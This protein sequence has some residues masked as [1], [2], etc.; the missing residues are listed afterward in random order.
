MILVAGA[1]VREIV[2]RLGEEVGFRRSLTCLLH[3]LTLIM[4]VT[5]RVMMRTGTVMR[6]GEQLAMIGQGFRGVQLF[7]NV[8]GLLEEEEVMGMKPLYSRVEHLLRLLLLSCRVGYLPTSR[9][10]T[11]SLH[12]YSKQFLYPHLFL[13]LT[14]VQILVVMTLRPMLMMEK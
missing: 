7:M 2:N 4:R 8:R 13:H 3:L 9:G 5:V 10:T 11:F 1:G 6:S 12:L 14:E